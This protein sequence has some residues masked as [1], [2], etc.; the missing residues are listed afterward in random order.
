[1]DVNRQ[2]VDCI[3]KE[4]LPLKM[5]GKIG[6]VGPETLEAHLQLFK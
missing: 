2:L 5:G 6:R 4:K 3:S 1:M